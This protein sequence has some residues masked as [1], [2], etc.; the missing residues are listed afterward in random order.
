MKQINNYLTESVDSRD[1]MSSAAQHF[2]DDWVKYV[3]SLSHQPS[4]EFYMSAIADSFFGDKAMYMLK[5][6]DVIKGFE[7]AIE[8]LKELKNKD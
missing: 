5:T 6:D 1:V 2:K 8:R 3:K 7:A 4:F